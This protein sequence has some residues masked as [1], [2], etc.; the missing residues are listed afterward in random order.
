MVMFNRYMM[1]LARES[2]GET[3]TDLAKSLGV[4]QGTVSKY[5]SG[6]NDPPPEFVKDLSDHL[7]YRTDFFFEIG[8]PYKLTSGGCMME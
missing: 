6:L 7:R 4:T 1:V 8:R 3:Q 5:E 2:R